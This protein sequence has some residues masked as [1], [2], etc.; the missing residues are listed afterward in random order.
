MM[1]EKKKNKRLRF[2]FCGRETTDRPSVAETLLAY[3]IMCV[4]NDNYH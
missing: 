3:Y 4:F 1:A 2:N